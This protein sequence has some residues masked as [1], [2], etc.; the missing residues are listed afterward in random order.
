MTLPELRKLFS[1]QF[2]DASLSLEECMRTWK[3]LK[4][5]EI[6]EVIEKETVHNSDPI[7]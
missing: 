2:N 4:S 5:Q 6:K 3:L 1:Q 7:T